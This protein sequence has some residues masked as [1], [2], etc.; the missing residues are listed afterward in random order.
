L[1]EIELVTLRRLKTSEEDVS[2]SLKSLDG[3]ALDVEKDANKEEIGDTENSQL[4]EKPVNSS[5]SFSVFNNECS[6]FKAVE[7]SKQLEN[8]KKDRVKTKACLIL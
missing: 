5:V 1:D 4:L 2:D 8:S 6:L 3:S 7:T